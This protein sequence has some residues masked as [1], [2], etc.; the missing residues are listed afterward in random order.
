MENVGML[1]F[2]ITPQSKA[3]YNTTLTDRRFDE[4][5][6]LIVYGSNTSGLNTLVT[7]A[8]KTQES[9]K[10]V[11]DPKQK[12]A[13]QEK[14]IQDI[15]SYQEKLTQTQQKVDPNFIP[16]NPRP[17]TPPNPTGHCSR[18][19]TNKTATGIDKEKSTISIRTDANRNDDHSAKPNPLSIPRYP[20]STCFTKQY[21]LSESN[22]L[23][24]V[25]FSLLPSFTLPY[26]SRLIKAK[27]RRA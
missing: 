5:Q 4:A 23:L 24:C 25:T 11:D 15:N 12:E 22:I 26:N 1:V 6:K 8:V 14:L 20:N 10:S 2:S 16:P 13:L 7:Q 17:S 27:T 19:R 18:H 3:S 21:F 9:V